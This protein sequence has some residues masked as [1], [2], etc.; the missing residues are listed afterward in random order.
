MK[1]VRGGE[2]L[3]VFGGLFSKQVVAVALIYLDVTDGDLNLFGD[4]I[5]KI[6]EIENKLLKLGKNSFLI[7]QSA[8][9][10]D[11]FFSPMYI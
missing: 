8:N 5:L 11:C 9:S 2:V 7:C 10:F 3:Q 1:L 4:T 6:L